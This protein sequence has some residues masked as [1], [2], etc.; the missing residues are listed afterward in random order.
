MNK[1]TNIKG[2]KKPATKKG[3]K[4]LNSYGKSRTKAKAKR[5]LTPADRAAFRGNALKGTSKWKATPPT[6]RRQER[7]LAHH[8]WGFNGK[9]PNTTTRKYKGGSK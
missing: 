9:S 2:R 7:D 5:N 6:R 4:T 8:K 3:Q 1:K